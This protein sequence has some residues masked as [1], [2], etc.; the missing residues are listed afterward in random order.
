MGWIRRL[1]YGWHEA[2]IERLHGQITR[3]MQ[4]ERCLMRV[5]T[6]AERLIADLSEAIR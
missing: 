3:L 6:E 4:R 5:K 2:E 1:I